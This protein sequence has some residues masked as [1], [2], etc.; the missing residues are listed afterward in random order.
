MKLPKSSEANVGAKLSRSKPHS[1]DID[2]ALQG[3]FTE[4]VDH[5][6]AELCRL[7]LRDSRLVPPNRSQPGTG[8]EVECRKRVGQRVLANLHSRQ[9]KLTQRVRSLNREI[10]ARCDI[11]EAIPKLVQQPW[12]NRI[13][14]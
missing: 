8:A 9:V 2:S 10:D 1:A 12:G 3:M 7:R 14:V 5:V 6:I 4:S 13:S 11:R